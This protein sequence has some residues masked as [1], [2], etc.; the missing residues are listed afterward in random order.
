MPPGGGPGPTRPERRGPV[1][2]LGGSG[3]LGSTVAAR[4]ARDGLEVRVVGRRAAVAPPGT[5]FA[6][7]DVTD[8][9]QLAA[10]VEDATAIVHLVSRLLPGTSW[11]VAATDVA[12]ARSNVQPA[13]DL[14]ELLRQSGR[15]PVVVTAGTTTQVGLPGSAPLQGGEPDAPCTPYDRQKLAVEN[16]LL[17]ATSAGVLRGVP[18]RLPTVYGT[19]A[20]T[21]SVG[22]GVVVTM[23]RRAVAG[24]PLTVW[25]SGAVVRD[26]LHVDD[27]AD[28]VAR[29]VHPDGPVT[30]LAGRSWLV[31][32]GQVTTLLRL[33]ELIAATVAAATGEAPVRVEHVAPPEHAQSVDG[34]GYRVDSTAFRAVTGWS[35]QVTLPAGIA[36]L[37]ERILA[38]HRARGG[39]PP[40]L[41]A[42]PST[43]PPQPRVSD[44]A[45]P[46][47]I[48]T[49][50]AES[51]DHD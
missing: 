41:A 46:T 7:A 18:L 38:E 51:P 17:G 1:V 15:V 3:Y 43:R 36:G 30:A 34:H 44:R 29:A 40:T 35:P 23:V 45:G 14:V 19:G 26:L 42:L 50:D 16:I 4:L 12:A 32:T 2:V 48:P 13:V 11:R 28:A 47:P 9:R 25:G 27:V 31:G 5:C 8:R 37:V 49:T 20:G 33:F 10:V 22:T 24:V 21:G 39:P 6:L